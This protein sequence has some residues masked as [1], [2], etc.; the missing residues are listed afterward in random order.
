MK[1]GVTSL[2]SVLIFA[3]LNE[4]D[5]KSLPD[6][7]IK[8]GNVSNE[9]KLA[10]L[11]SHAELMKSFMNVSV[12]PCDD[13]YEYACGNWPNVKPD[14]Y[15]AGKMGS[16]SALIYTTNNATEHLL[17][18]NQLAE[19]LNVS[20]ELRVAQ[21]FYNACL[22]AEL[23]PFPAADPAY[24][25]LIRLI[26][27]FPA[28]DGDKWNASN[29]S[30]LNMSAHLTNY[31]AK[32]LIFD[33]L[34]LKYPFEPEFK[35]PKLGFDFIV[36]TENLESNT[37]RSKQLNEDRMRG[38]L[39]AYQL[40]EDQITEVIAGVFAFWRDVLEVVDEFF[41]DEINCHMMS[42]VL[43]ITPLTQWS[44]Y[45]DI[46][47]KGANVTKGHT[48]NYY[49]V[50]LDELCAK[51]TAAVANYLAMKL[52]YT[53]DA[54]L[55]D[56]KHQRDYCALKTSTTMGYLLD[57]LY[58]KVFFSEEKRSE[59]SEIV[60]EIR[61]SLRLTLE[62][63][64]WL[65]P[66]TKREALLKESAIKANIGSIKD[67]ALTDRIMRQI[68][69]LAINESNYVAT[70]IEVHR[71]HVS[72][73][74]FSS[75]HFEELSNKTKPLLL[76]IGMQPV[77]AYSILDNSINLL[78]GLL[79]SPVYHPFWPDA[80]KFG[81]LGFVLGHELTHGFDTFG[82]LFDGNGEP[83]SWWTALSRDQFEDK[84]QCFV[85]Q[86]SKY[87]VPL[88]NQTID[89][90]K[91]MDEN[92]A[93]NGGIREAFSAY[94]RRKTQRMNNH[95]QDKDETLPGLDLSPE[96][97]FFLGLAQFFCTDF[98]EETYWNTLTDSHTTDKFRVLGSIANSKDF[99]KAYN[100]SPQ[101]NSEMC[102][103]W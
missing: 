23:Y 89:G 50:K 100:C 13:F 16:L 11:K 98:Q 82:F 53:M 19:T 83:R 93:D 95:D 21:Q 51:H 34:S 76:M 1:I 87:Q 31:G 52:L 59:V 66:E 5:S 20:K 35:I 80:L 24:L 101:P 8:S 67:E 54:K 71:L 25:D 103:L 56:P 27:G 69:S 97:L 70:N 44:S 45:Y 47:W 86:Y 49:Y 75:L 99:A 3:V 94:T 26:G 77:A 15:Y 91:T 84:A 17:G 68:G 48:C 63:A 10:Y 46:A 22:A 37:S 4:V 14:R 55:K 32:G 88:V 41:K 78:A 33:E 57:K 73:E 43:G 81:T 64:E 90:K 38:Y 2:L 12:P 30:W 72:N 9:A 42:S 39:R 74:R 62:E 18:L 36:Y 102:S 92:I 6:V 61:K 79:D 85:D 40:P 7:S 96:Q 60:Q 29:F 65:D 28:V 58:M